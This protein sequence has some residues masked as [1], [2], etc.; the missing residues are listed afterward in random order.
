MRCTVHLVR[1]S[2]RTSKL[3]NPLVHL[4]AILFLALLIPGTGRR[5]LRLIYTE[6]RKSGSPDFMQRPCVFLR[7]IYA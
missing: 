4:Y 7:C 1:F 6:S 3:S 5:E 2:S